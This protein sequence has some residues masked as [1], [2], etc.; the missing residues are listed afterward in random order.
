V[1]ALQALALAAAG[2]QAGALALPGWLGWL[3]QLRIEG[4]PAEPEPHAER[5][6]QPA[7]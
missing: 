1:R 3:P 5:E 7:R 2:D 6:P 4:V